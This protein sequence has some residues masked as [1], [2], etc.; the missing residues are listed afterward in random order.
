MERFKKLLQAVGCFMNADK[1]L[2]SLLVVDD[3]PGTRNTL[4][5]CFPWEDIGFNI[6]FQANNGQEALDYIRQ[7]PVDVVL[8]DIRMPVLSGIDLARELYL[9]KSPTKVVFLS[10]Y[11]NFEYAK[12][13]LDFGVKNYILK[14][15]KY[16]ELV[17]VFSRIKSEL[18][19][20]RSRYENQDTRTSDDKGQDRGFSLEDGVISTIKNYVQRN[21]RSATLEDVA[22]VVH[23]N[24]NYLS[25]YFKQKTG[26]NFSDF[27]TEVKMKNAAELLKN[28]DLKIHQVGRMVGYSNAK[29]FAR[30]FKKYFGVTPKQYR[31]K[32]G[33]N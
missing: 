8:C 9:S 1:K 11:R 17:D 3:E 16:K 32:G 28:I 2:Y 22:K 4:C 6:V 13:A 31:H 14:P 24:P 12:K 10:G 18:D 21:Y 26:E 30:S 25:Y 7:H 27:L 15:A 19:E 5:S 23:M 20:E 29:N 33:N